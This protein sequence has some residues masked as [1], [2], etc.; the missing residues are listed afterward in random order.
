[1]FVS[2]V[3][4]TVELA[5]AAALWHFVVTKQW[6]ATVKHSIDNFVTIG[7]P[8]GYM[9]QKQNTN[10]ELLSRGTVE[11]TSWDSQDRLLPTVTLRIHRFSQ[12]T[13]QKIW[14]TTAVI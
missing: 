13:Q 5:T 12:R 8:L 2:Q 10:T 6:T 9:K 1:M 4:V 11:C 3:N 7:T 14:H